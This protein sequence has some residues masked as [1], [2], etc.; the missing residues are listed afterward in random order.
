MW[1]RAALAA[2]SCALGCAGPSGSLRIAPEPGG[3]T[4]GRELLPDHDRWLAQFAAADAGGWNRARCREIARGFEQVAARDVRARPSALYNAG[5]AYERCSMTKDARAAYAAAGSHHARAKLLLL[6]HAAGAPI[7]ATIERFAYLVAESKFA[8]PDL[9]VKLGA[10]HLRRGEPS[11]FEAARKSAQRALAIDDAHVPALDLLAL[12]YLGSANGRRQALDLAALI[13]SQAIAK[14]PDHAPIHN[15]AGMVA[16]ALG[17][18]N[19]AIRSFRRARELDPKSFEAQM[20]YAAVSFSIRGWE[21]AR[22]A[23]RV[24]V[25]LRPN[26]YEAHLGLALALRALA[27]PGDTEA[28]DESRR[29]LHVAK[30]LAP[31]RPEAYFNEARLLEEVVARRASGE[32]AVTTLERARELYDEFGKR[33]GS[34]EPDAVVR[35]REHREDVQ[36]KIRFLSDA[37]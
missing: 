25:S 34:A 9:L 7:G 15:T 35:A 24:A 32:R 16:V 31:E 36:Q 30:R 17:D 10:L 6:D 2:L 23:Y 1:G 13:A 19:A 8:H 27:K 4:P 26:D 37:P 20:N 18:Y 11:D 28:V 5:L 29:H 33:A 3:A 14:R 22:D 12:A 21:Q